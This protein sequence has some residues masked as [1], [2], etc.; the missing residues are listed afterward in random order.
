MDA[1]PRGK[2]RTRVGDRLGTPCSEAAEPAAWSPSDA[3]HRIHQQARVEH[4]PRE[5]PQ[6]AW[7]DETTQQLIGSWTLVSADEEGTLGKLATAGD[8]CSFNP[9]HSLVCDGEKA[10]EAIWR[11]VRAWPQD[12]FDGLNRLDVSASGNVGIHGTYEISG[13]TMTWDIVDSVWQRSG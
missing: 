3:G 5:K 9:D 11:S 7:S 10:R 4:L 6:G 12:L 8:T 2:L 1:S 13:D